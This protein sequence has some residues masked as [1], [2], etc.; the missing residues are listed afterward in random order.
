MATQALSLAKLGDFNLS[1]ES[2]EAVLKVDSLCLEAIWIK[3]LSFKME[4]M[5]KPFILGRVTL[6][7]LSI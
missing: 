7:R 5:F 6:Q 1:R 3:E 4:K 2:A